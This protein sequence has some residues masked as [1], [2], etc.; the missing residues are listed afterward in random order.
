LND[1]VET[2]MYFDFKDATADILAKS[3][4]HGELCDLPLDLIYSEAEA[5]DSAFNGDMIKPVVATDVP[6]ASSEF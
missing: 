4:L 5:Y 6:V 3:S 2:K 1:N